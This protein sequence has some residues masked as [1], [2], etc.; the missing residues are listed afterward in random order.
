[1]LVGWSQAD[2]ASAAELGLA[3]IQRLEAQNDVLRG[4]SE[5]I[6]KVQIALEDAGIIFIDGDE[7]NGPGVRLSKP[8]PM[9]R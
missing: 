7:T 6:W 5:T 4:M 3:T 9:A 8:I 1:V 2:L